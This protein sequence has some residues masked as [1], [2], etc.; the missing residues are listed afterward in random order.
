M[1]LTAARMPSIAPATAAALAPSPVSPAPTG[2]T[3]ASNSGFPGMI[4][5]LFPSPIGSQPPPPPFTTS[6][7]GIAGSVGGSNGSSVVL[8]HNVYSFHY[9]APSHNHSKKC[10]TIVSKPVYLLHS[11][12][13]HHVNDCGI[14]HR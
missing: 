6:G 9:V 2:P 3:T 1:E 11:R 14:M 7:S 5:M 4:T 10:L 12:F 8:Q 13:Q